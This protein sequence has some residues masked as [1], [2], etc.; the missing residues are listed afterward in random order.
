MTTTVEVELVEAIGAFVLSL[1]L[2]A[3]I[4]AWGRGVVA[5]AQYREL[6]EMKRVAVDSVQ[7]PQCRRIT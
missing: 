5:L 3:V 4:G 1:L 7:C 6:V 2:G